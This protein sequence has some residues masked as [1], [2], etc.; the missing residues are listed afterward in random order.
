MK[1]L[2]ICIPAYNEE[3]NIE[4]LLVILLK[5]QI[6]KNYCL[7]LIIIASDGSSDNTVN[8]VK[9]IAKKNKNVKLLDFKKREGKTK[10]MNIF[11]R[12]ANEDILVML[13]ADV[14]PENEFTIANLILPFS[15]DANIALVS[16]NPKPIDKK[17]G[18]VGRA[19]IF[20]YKLQKYLKEN[21]RGGNN[22]YGC[23]GRILALKKRFYKSTKM[24]VETSIND[25]QLYLDC[26]E[27]K[28]DFVFISTAVVFYK[29]PTTVK[30][31]L[32]Q[33]QR[34][35]LNSRIMERF[36]S[37]KD[38]INIPKFFFLKGFLKNLRSD[39]V[40]GLTWAII[41]NYGLCL[42]S[43][44]DALAA[45]WSISDSTKELDN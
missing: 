17:Y 35:R 38:E 6:P 42:P 13:D 26:K 7:R 40:G 32:K 8:I 36:P 5:Q 4:R 33:S 43:K 45:T 21:L 41:Y 27:K 1:T 14:L 22:F 20:S 16:G 24:P 37:M 3:K 15:Q 31:F 30:D 44:K 19:S 39:P 29:P 10:L 18:L 25:G 34:F 2:T 9:E 12:S 23:H 28:F 11:F